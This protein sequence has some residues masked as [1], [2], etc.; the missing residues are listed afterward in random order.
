MNIQ[1]TQTNLL[2]LLAGI[3]FIAVLMFFRLDAD[4]VTN[5]IRRH[6]YGRMPCNQKCENGCSG[7]QP[8]A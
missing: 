7:G 2:G 4:A 8:P 3:M 6:D 5:D 1:K